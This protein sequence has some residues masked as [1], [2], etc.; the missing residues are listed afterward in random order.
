MKHGLKRLSDII[1]VPG[2][3][4]ERRHLQRRRHMPAGLEIDEINSPCSQAAVA[5]GVL[6]N[7]GDDAVCEDV[8]GMRAQKIILDSLAEQTYPMCDSQ[9]MH[10][11]DALPL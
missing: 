5:F 9:A 8:L 7:C 6:F 1:G 10:M 4:I 11:L 2:E 3:R